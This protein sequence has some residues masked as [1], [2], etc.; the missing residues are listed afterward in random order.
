VG[1]GEGVVLPSMNALVA[2]HIAP[3]RKARAL[4][5]IF[6]GFH[7]GN[8]VGLMVSPAIILAYGWQAL[9][10][11]FGLLGGPLLALWLTVTPHHTMQ[12]NSKLATYQH[13]PGASP[14]GGQELRTAVSARDFLTRSAVVAI[15]ICNFVN[16]WGYFIFLSWIPS[17]FTTV[18]GMDLRASSLMAFV[19]W[20]AMAGGSSIAGVIADYLVQHMPVRLS[21][22]T[23]T[24]SSSSNTRKGLTQKACIFAATAT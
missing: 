10:L 18:F 24:A 8:L 6:T 15:V 11:Q 20:I 4:G 5:A 19:P 9:F 2:T 22:R 16:H 1:T 17:Y 14:G 3:M 12:S 7:C 13:A 23:P 21:D